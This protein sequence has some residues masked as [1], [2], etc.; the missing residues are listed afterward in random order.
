MAHRSQLERIH[1][2]LSRRHADFGERTADHRR[3][4]RRPAYVDVTVLD[5]G[6]QLAE[7]GR[8]E[9]TRRVRIG[10]PTQYVPHANAAFWGQ[11]V[12]LVAEDQLVA[13]TRAIDRD[14]A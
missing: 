3:E 11:P 7:T 12:E 8:R 5:V 9:Q 4:P 2:H 14:G 1:V 13:G 10:T 6:D